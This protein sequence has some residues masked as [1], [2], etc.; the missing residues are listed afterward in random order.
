MKESSAFIPS[1]PPLLAL[2]LT[3]SLLLA[4]ALEAWAYVY[5]VKPGG[6]GDGSSWEK[7]LGERGLIETLDKSGNGHEF[8]LAAGTYRPYVPDEP[9]GTASD[10]ETPPSERSFFLNPGVAMFGGFSGNETA[11]S[12]RDWERNTT[13]LSGLIDLPDS[14]TT[15]S[16]HVVVVSGDLGY[17]STLD[18]FTISGGGAV[19]DGEHA[20]G[21]GMRLTD[22]YTIIANCTFQDN[23]ASRGGGLY[24]RGGAPLVRD[25]FFIENEASNQG[26]GLYNEDS[27]LSVTD[28]S[29]ADN[30]ARLGGAMMNYAAGDTEGASAAQ[31]STPSIKRSSFY[32]NV[33]LEAGGAVSNWRSAAMVTDSSFSSNR[34]FIEGGAMFNRECSPQISACTFDSNRAENG[35]AVTNWDS[36]PV[37]TNCTFFSNSAAASGGGMLNDKSSVIVVNSTFTRN[38]ASSGGAM[39]SFECSPIVANSI[40]WGNGTEIRTLGGT[41][42]VSYSIVEGGHAGERNIDEDP[43]LGAL[44]N[45]GGFTDTCL[46]HPESPAVDSGMPVGSR[47][48]GNVVVPAVDQRGTARPKGTGVD[49]GAC[50]YSEAPDPPAPA[51]GGGGGGCESVPAGAGAALVLLPLALLLP[52]R[53]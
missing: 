16:Y 52:R 18:G 44:L 12:Q 24:V 31:I 38:R 37:M 47:V 15:R 9:E 32:G 39:F 36:D 51:P 29:F 53:R 4:P 22:G 11:R 17:P 43:R 6:T 3:A 2:L 35:G 42:T 50:E 28:C 7:A 48:S 13:V 10:D 5:R 1:R 34:S 49:M 26:G 41:I 25:T 19:G 14:T 21:G 8:W 30:R 40:L 45:N 23:L 20:L 27:R 33:A 46:P